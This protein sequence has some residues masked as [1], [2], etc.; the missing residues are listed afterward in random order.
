[1]RRLILL[2][3]VIFAAAAFAQQEGGGRRGPMGEPKNLKILK[4]DQV[5]TTMRAFTVALGVRC[6][7]CHVQGDFA[8]DEKP[9]KVTARRMM[10]MAHDINANFFNG[11]QRVTCYTCHRGSEHPQ[12][13]P[14]A[15]AGGPGPGAAPPPPPPP[16]QQ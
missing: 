13:A 6:T 7:G 14:E 4:P 2:S 8:S 9:E 12:T 10:Q 15:G 3:T 16:P 11:N 5:M 1:M